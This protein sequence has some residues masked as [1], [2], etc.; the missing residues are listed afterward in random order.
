MSKNIL[1]TGGSGYVAQSLFNCL[2]HDNKITL[3]TRKELDLANPI[4]T[5]N[6]FKDKHFDCVLHT[7]ITGGNRSVIDTSDTLDNNLLLYYNLLRNQDHFTKFIN[8][9][10]GAELY[11]NNTPYGLS[12]FVIYKSILEKRNFFNIRI[13]AVFDENENERRFI[14]SN[15]IRYINKQPLVIHKNKFMDF[16]YMEDLLNLV[17]FYIENEAPP[18]TIDCTYS[19]SSTLLNIT[20]KINNLG[21]YQCD[22][23]ILDNIDMDAPY[24]GEHTQ[25]LNYIGLYNGIKN[26]YGLLYK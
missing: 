12:K 25:L 26:V 5:N 19:S 14:K 3:L 23:N 16:F 22:V 1:I 11:S 18:K 8:F 15:I 7:A 13:F 6:W 21:S 2:K 24:T 17:R 10:S 4:E 9:G 20:K